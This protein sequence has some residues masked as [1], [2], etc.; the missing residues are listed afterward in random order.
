[1]NIEL[2]QKIQ[3]AIRKTVLEKKIGVAFSGGVDSTLIS[4]IL[5]EEEKLWLDMQLKRIKTNR[6]TNKIK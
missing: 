5:H 1:M 2:L 6:Y 4:K 3:D